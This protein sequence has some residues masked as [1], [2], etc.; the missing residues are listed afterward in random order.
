M[1]AESFNALAAAPLLAG[2][3]LPA[4]EL[5][6]AEGIVS[7]FPAGVLIVHEGDPGH[8][9]FIIV[10]GEVEVLKTNAAGH[11]VALA[12]FKAGTFFGEMCVVDPVP[13]AASVRAVV[14][15]QTIEIRASTLYHLFQKMPDQY[16]IMILNLS[17]DMARRLRQLDETYAAKAG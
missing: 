15:V 3:K 16:A 13:R 6:A 8:S 2:M 5:L 9:F 10:Q 7:S 1:D 17:R 12:W 11:A 14:P 4:L